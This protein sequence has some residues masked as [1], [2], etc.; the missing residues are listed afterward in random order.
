MFD[1]N[2]LTLNLLNNLQLD[3]FNQDKKQGEKAM[4]ID[5]EDDEEE[6]F[7]EKSWC[8]I[9]DLLSTGDNTP[10]LVGQDDR[11]TESDEEENLNIFENVDTTLDNDFTP[12]LTNLSTLSSTFGSN[13]IMPKLLL[14][15]NLI[16]VVSNAKGTDLVVYLRNLGMTINH[17]LL[18]GDT[19][20]TVDKKSN[21]KTS[22]DK[23][24][25]KPTGLG[26]KISESV[27]NN[28][29]PVNVKND[30]RHSLTTLKSDV[31]DFDV[32]GPKTLDTTTNAY[33]ISNPGR[34]GF[35]EVVKPYDA[36]SDSTD[37][38]ES[39]ND[40]EFLSATSRGESGKCGV[41]LKSG[42]QVGSSSHNN[43]SS[44][45]GL[46]GGSV[47]VNDFDESLSTVKFDENG[48]VVS[49]G[50]LRGGKSVATVVKRGGKMHN[51]EKSLPS[52][53]SVN[54]QGHKNDNIKSPVTNDSKDND[55]S[56]FSSYIEIS[57]SEIDPKHSESRFSLVK[58]TSVNQ[59][60]TFDK[61]SF[62]FADEMFNNFDFSLPKRINQ[63]YDIRL[64][65]TYMLKNCS[66]SEPNRSLIQIENPYSNHG[67]SELNTSHLLFLINDG[68]QSFVKFLSKFNTKNTKLTIIN[69]TTV[70]Y[71][72][73]LF[74]LISIMKPCQVWKTGSV[75]SISSKMRAFI[76][77]EFDY[78]Y[79]E[80][81]VSVATS[82]QRNK[83]KSQEKQ[84][85]SELVDSTEFIDP[86][87]MSQSFSKLSL[88]GKIIKNLVYD[89][90]IDIWLF[91]GFTFGI[92]LGISLSNPHAFSNVFKKNE[93][94]PVVP[95]STFDE[96]Q[97]LLRLKAM[98]L[99]VCANQVL[100]Y[101]RK[102]FEKFMGLMLSIC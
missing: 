67:S 12:D 18:S 93:V 22:V 80:L 5:K 78:H 71:F 91:A 61:G 40:D 97:D 20:T 31:V 28:H 56:L 25:N 36:N 38:K 55:K 33:D 48:N 27:K 14:N 16:T 76:D 3:A 1:S 70:N 92:G 26:I 30:P 41:N 13:L 73:N 85:K 65:K 53:V 66:R 89:F 95:K 96:C 62:V 60:N 84:F 9:K 46:C 98:G 59:S 58:T 29:T 94:I 24:R 37:I 52:T 11:L 45:G 68:S 69:I 79:D 51:S 102:G 47:N 64:P 77:S 88:V 10:L 44:S 4:K 63:F 43:K 6:N 19:Q 72:T 32:L 42:S 8:D 100:N 21:N 15:Q 82:V 39:S 83:Y 7:K 2:L 54:S 99:K 49:S 17:V 57:D 50:Y 35:V 34:N 81:V 87:N 23:T 101:V 86:L 90:P 74:D 75:L